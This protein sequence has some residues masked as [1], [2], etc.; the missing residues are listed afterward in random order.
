MVAKNCLYYRICMNW[1]CWAKEI[2][3]P[4]LSLPGP[5]AFRAHVLSLSYEESGNPLKVHTQKKLLTFMFLSR[6]S[7][8]GFHKIV[9]EV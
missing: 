6:K 2:F 4:T 3:L 1:I 9:I 8:Y 7:D 5:A